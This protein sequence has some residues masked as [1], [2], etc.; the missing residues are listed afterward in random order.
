MR[1]LQIMNNDNSFSLNKLPVAGVSNTLHNIDAVDIYAQAE[2]SRVMPR[3][4]SSGSQ[5][6]EQQVK[7]RII[8]TDDS[9][10]IRVAIGYQNG[11]F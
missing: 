8:V 6:G 4:L 9:G 3:Q 2:Q 5:R 11:G 10:E 1:I 7:G